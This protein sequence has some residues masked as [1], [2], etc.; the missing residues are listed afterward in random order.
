MKRKDISVNFVNRERRN[1]KSRTHFQRSVFSLVRQKQ[2]AEGISF[3][4]LKRI[5]IRQSFVLIGRDGEKTGKYSS[6]IGLFGSIL[7]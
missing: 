7:L 3:D 6:I 4:W 2:N 5:K 1:T